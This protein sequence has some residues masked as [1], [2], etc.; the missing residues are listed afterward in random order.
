MGVA[1]MTTVIA[2]TAMRFVVPITLVT[3]IA[4]LL[5]G[6]NLPG[7][8][9]IGAVLAATAVALV[10]VVGGLDYLRNVLGIGPTDDGFDHGPVAYYRSV[11]ALGLV[12]TSGSGL[13]PVILG[14]PFLTQTF[15]ILHHVPI[16]GELEVASALAFDVGVFLTVVGALL[17]VIAV[18]G[19]E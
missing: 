10:Y 18:V 15:R 5:Q 11:F 3:A 1:L 12:L 13:V 6:H 4:L 7:G 14:Y 8:G 16:Y 17:T 9:F 19:S 2:R